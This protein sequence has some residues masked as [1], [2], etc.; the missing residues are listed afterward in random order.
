[1]AF[2]LA[3]D[4]NHMKITLIFRW[5]WSIFSQLLESFQVSLIIIEIWSR[6]VMGAVSR[7][8]RGIRPDIGISSIMIHKIP[9]P[10]LNF[11]MLKLLFSTSCYI[12]YLYESYLILSQL[13]FRSK[14]KPIFW[15]KLLDL[16]LVGSTLT[17]TG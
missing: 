5:W 4:R 6:R 12:M 9:H 1:M 10:Y 16:R 11:T 2:D 17:K 8:I 15:L 13:I 14:T 7:M 3:N